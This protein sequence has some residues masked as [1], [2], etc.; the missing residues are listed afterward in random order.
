M[1]RRTPTVYAF[2]DESGDP[3]S[4]LRKG[5]SSF[6][7]VVFVETTQPDMLRENLQD[8]RVE[9]NLPRTFE[10]RYHDTRMTWAR[11]AFF[12]L[13]RSMDVRV[14][15][16]VVD[17][18][19]L[20]LEFN[21]YGRIAMNQFVVG[22]L[23]MRAPQEQLHDAVLVIDGERGVQTEALVNG[24]RTYLTRLYRER[25][26]VRAFQKIVVR[27]ARAE[28]GLQYADMVAGV[29]AE[30]FERGKSNYDKVVNARISDLWVYPEE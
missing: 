2:M 10:F 27:G 9:F 16:A 6:F 7:I 15:A 12:T 13:L 26:R 28:D 21:H 3:G 5:A 25:T 1:R 29:L 22:E 11:E 30:R 8:L 14:R 20:P 19:R 18:A 17:K 24:L 23:V 4:N